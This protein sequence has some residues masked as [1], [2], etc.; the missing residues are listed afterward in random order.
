MK[1]ILI[2]AFL[3]LAAFTACNSAASLP[4]GFVGRPYQANVPGFAGESP[5]NWSVTGGTLPDGLALGPAAGEIS[6]TPSRVGRFDFT[7]RVTD[8]ASP[9]RETVKDYSIRV[10]QMTG[11]AASPTTDPA[12]STARWTGTL[13]S[14]VEARFTPAG[15]PPYSC[16]SVHDATLTL[17]ANGQG[18]ISGVGSA[19]C[20]STNCR[21]DLGRF[22]NPLNFR[23]EGQHEPNTNWMSLRFVFGEISQLRTVNY[24]EA[25]RMDAVQDQQPCLGFNVRYFNSEPLRVTILSTGVAEGQDTS[26]WT[27]NSITNYATNTTI[28]LTCANCTGSS[29]LTM[30]DTRVQR[31]TR[32]RSGMLKLSPKGTEWAG[33]L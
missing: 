9:R 24:F 32:I 31:G 23:V 6:G 28:S 27:P 8:S 18:Q 22:P 2:I 10:L 4:D 33:D 25:E 21:P 17:V 7:V 12:S 15:A 20:S 29:W 1:S 5:L 11:S 26:N 13:R 16:T 19:V 3:A 30:R 14:E